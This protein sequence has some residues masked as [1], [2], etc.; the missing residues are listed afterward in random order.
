MNCQIKFSAAPILQNS[1]EKILQRFSATACQHITS[2][3]PS[4]HL[5]GHWTRL[6]LS[7]CLP[8]KF[9]FFSIAVV[10]VRFVSTSAAKQC[11]LFLINKT[12]T[13]NLSTP[14]H[15]RHAKM[16]SH[17]FKYVFLSTHMTKHVL[18]IIFCWF[19]FRSLSFTFLNPNCL[20]WRRHILSAL[21][22]LTLFPF[23]G[24]FLNFCSVP[25]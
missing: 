7:P 18:L 21:M 19:F 14:V 9:I 6:C 20:T 8:F 17:I 10:V 5:L 22:C 25:S 15:A 12:W 4:T 24:V 11:F 13:K 3:T 2:L 1:Q 16:L 23:L